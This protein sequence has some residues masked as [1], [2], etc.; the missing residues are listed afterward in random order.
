MASCLFHRA[1]TI[2]V[3]ENIQMEERHLRMVLRTN[4]YPEHAIQ[5]AAR[6]RKKKTTPEEQT[7]YTICLP[8]VARIG[9]NQRRVCRK[10]NIRTVFTTTNTL[11]QQLTKVKDTDPTLKRSSVVYSIPCSCG[12]KYIGETK[13]NLEA[14]LKEHQIA[15]RRGETDKSAIAEHAWEKQHQPQWNIIKILDRARN[16]SILLIKEALHIMMTDQH[17]L[18]NRDQGLAVVDCWRPLLKKHFVN[19]NVTPSSHVAE[20]KF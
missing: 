20:S 4:G 15:T 16:E 13:R 12:Q 7:K 17:S 6:P 5:D 19:D 8:Y 14:R 3:G 18:L 10:F 9:Q 11:R 2:A 1:R